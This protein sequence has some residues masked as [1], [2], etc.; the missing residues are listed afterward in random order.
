MYHLELTLKSYELKH[1][2]FKSI[3]LIVDAPINIIGNHVKITVLIKTDKR[4]KTKWISVMTLKVRGGPE[5]E[6][7]YRM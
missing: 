5:F 2:L 7:Q 6:K 3:S 4:G 1:L